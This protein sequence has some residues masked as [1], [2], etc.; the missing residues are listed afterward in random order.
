[1]SLRAGCALALLCAS[2]CGDNVHLGGG[3][4]L[5]PPRVG[6]RTNETGAA[7]TFT[8]SLTNAQVHDIDVTVTSLDLAEGTVSPG[9]LHFTPDT[10]DTPQ[11]VTVRGVDDDRADGNQTYTVRL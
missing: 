10:Y 3:D 4:L 1:M 6:L 7:A 2:A 11:L 8:V 9:T 5:I